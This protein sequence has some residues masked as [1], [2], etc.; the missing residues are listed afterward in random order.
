MMAQDENIFYSVSATTR[1]P[2]PGEEHGTHYYFLKKDEFERLIEQDGML[3]YAS[4]VEN[5]YGTPKKAVYEQMESGKDVVLEIEVQGAMQIKEKCPDAVFI[6]VMPPSMEELRRRLV[7]RKTEDMDTINHRLSTAV[8]E[9]RHADR[10]DY[11]VVNDTVTE[12]V[13][14]ISSIIQAEKNKVSRMNDFIEE[15]LKN[16]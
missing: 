16:A 9:M 15:V 13:N 2:R 14:R 11:V 7:D 12:A 3:E 4:Y 6:F 5:Y 10:Y 8:N 1:E